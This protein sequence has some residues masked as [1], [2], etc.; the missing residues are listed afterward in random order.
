MP[1]KYYI[2]GTLVKCIFGALDSAFRPRLE[3]K[4]RVK[5]QKKDK[6][7]ETGTKPDI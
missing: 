7:E 1:H 6:K 2:I 3:M 5:I 4:D